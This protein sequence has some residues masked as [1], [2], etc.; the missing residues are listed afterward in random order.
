M[1]HLRPE[2]LGSSQRHLRLYDRAPPARGQPLAIRRSEQLV[3]LTS[4]VVER[5]VFIDVVVVV[6]RSCGD[7]GSPLGLRGFTF[8]PAG[9][10]MWG[11]RHALRQG[12]EE[13]K[14]RAFGG[15]LAHLLKYHLNPFINQYA[16]GTPLVPL[17]AW[18]WDERGS[19]GGRVGGVM[20]SR[21]SR[22]GGY[23]TTRLWRTSTIVAV[24]AI[25]TETAS[26][27]DPL[28]GL[29]GLHVIGVQRNEVELRVE[30]ESARPEVTGCRALRDNRACAWPS[31][32]RV[33]RRAVL[34]CYGETTTV[35]T[36]LA[37]FRA[38]VFGDVVRGTGPRC[39][40]LR[41]RCSRVGLRLGRSGSWEGGRTRRF[42]AG[43]PTRLHVKDAV[44]CGS[45]RSGDCRGR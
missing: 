43:P 21:P 26:V 5:V 2:V 16:N 15:V 40:T 32:S 1:F 19:G 3:N 24:Q 35:K 39:S 9:H 12:Y 8:R 31:T 14:I 17:L 10:A 23:H 13:R 28:V 4:S 45:A 22:I 34:D 29:A 38:D 6:A 33:D 11:R 20:G 27:A 18:T 7:V 42:G 25:V 37:V 30:F 41:G 44:A 36:T